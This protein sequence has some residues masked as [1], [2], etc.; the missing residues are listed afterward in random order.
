M[1]K[2]DAGERVLLCA[3]DLGKRQ[4]AR[5]DTVKPGDLPD[6]VWRSLEAGDRLRKPEDAPKLPRDLPPVE[7]L[8]PATRAVLDAE[9]SVP[10]TPAEVKAALAADGPVAS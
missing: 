5:G 9:G 3:V 1:A 7:L 6:D 10:F 4:F 2:K 8:D